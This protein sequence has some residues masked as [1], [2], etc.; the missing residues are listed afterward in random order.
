M[1]KSKFQTVYGVRLYPLS[2]IMNEELTESDLN[3][4]FDTK[5]FKYSMII[6]MFR[7]VGNTKRNCDI[8]KLVT[9]NNKWVYENYWK[10]SQRN[11][12]EKILTKCIQNMYY[13]S[14]EKSKVIA[15]WYLFQFGM[16]IKGNKFDPSK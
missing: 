10:I 3:Y 1:A 4:L 11:E 8:I 6:G 7:F 9:K 5:S 13:Y 2:Y 14:E 16:S 12:F 15:Q